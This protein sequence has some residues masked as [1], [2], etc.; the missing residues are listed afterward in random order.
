VIP[1]RYDGDGVGA[2]LRG[3]GDGQDG[4]RCA[5][6]GGRRLGGECVDAVLGGACGDGDVRVLGARVWEDISGVLVV[7]EG[8]V[9][10]RVCGWGICRR[11]SW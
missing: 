9:V 4:P 3:A 10:D 5:G 2:A 1:E 6:F 7:V 8:V 11:C